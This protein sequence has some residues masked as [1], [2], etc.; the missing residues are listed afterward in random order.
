MNLPS[1]LIP[2]VMVESQKAG[3]VAAG[4][5]VL[6]PFPGQ[7]KLLRLKQDIFM[8]IAEFIFMLLMLYIGSRFGG[9][10]LGLVS[11]IGLMVEVF[12]LGY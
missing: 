12:I 8:L 2:G 7:R 1:F 5:F 6:S 11:G 3:S 9:I 4:L 10:G